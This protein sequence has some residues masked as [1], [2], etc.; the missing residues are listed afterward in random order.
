M[1]RLTLLV[2]VIEARPSAAEVVKRTCGHDL[3]MNRGIYGVRWGA[4][5]REVP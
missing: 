1:K 3:D 2:L 5:K 4:L